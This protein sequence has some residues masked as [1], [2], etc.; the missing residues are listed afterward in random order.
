MWAWATLPRNSANGLASYRP[1]HPAESNQ[2]NEYTVG[3][4]Q[5]LQGALAA[6]LPLGLASCAGD[7][8]AKKE[9]L[10]VGGLPVTCNLTLPIACT[11]KQ[12]SI[13]NGSASND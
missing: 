7:K 6:A 9:P 13:A 12:A 5:L 11:G 8:G 4:R 1:E 10:I 3:R 2:V